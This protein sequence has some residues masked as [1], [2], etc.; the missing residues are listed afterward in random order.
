MT[1]TWN[2]FLPAVKQEWLSDNDRKAYDGVC[3]MKLCESDDAVQIKKERS[4]H[5]A[6][7]PSKRTIPLSGRGKL[8][9]TL[10]KTLSPFEMTL[11]AKGRDWYWAGIR[12]LNEGNMIGH[13]AKG[14]QTS[15]SC[16]GADISI[17]TRHTVDSS[18]PQPLY[19][20]WERNVKI[21]YRPSQSLIDF[22][23]NQKMCDMIH[24]KSST[25]MKWHQLYSQV[26]ALQSAFKCWSHPLKSMQIYIH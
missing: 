14:P 19:G 12:R 1:S 16:I 22:S 15:H 4:N 8:T 26:S 10:I 25:S 6:K 5:V 23:I 18:Y 17:L 2:R 13:D 24:D 7:R 20:V 3:D 11:I 9:Q 21:N